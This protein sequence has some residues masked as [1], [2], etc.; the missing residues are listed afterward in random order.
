[1]V[2][3][4][5]EKGLCSVICLGYNHANFLKNNIESIWRQEY[6]KKEIIV[7][8]DGSKDNSLDLLQKLTA[9]APIPM[10]VISQEN[11][12]NIGRNFNNGLKA[13]RGEFVLFISLDDVLVDNIISM[14]ADL[15]NANPTLAFVANSRVMLI[16]DYG[17]EKT[18][19]D[20]LRID[21]MVDPSASDLL[22]L[23][24]EEFGAFY[25]QNC[26]LRRDVI[27]IV[28]GFNEDMIGDDIVLRIKIFRFLKKQQ[29][30]TFKIL[31]SVGACYRLH[32]NN[33]H[34]NSIRQMKI[35]TECLERFF[36]ERKNPTILLNW[37]KGVIRDSTFEE[38]IE[39]FTFNKRASNLLLEPEIQ[40][41]IF[42]SVIGNRGLY[43]P[44]FKKEKRGEDRTITMFGL[45]KYHYKK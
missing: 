17:S 28:G 15:M 11:T 25:L 41:E 23:E 44:L 8:D 29:K 16:D 32:D 5:Y 31:K 26:M 38:Y 42:K 20:S 12:G 18:S 7:V 36:P 39:M 10:T 30:Y 3:I 33:I 14:R 4:V 1:M 43:I 9:I 27:D 34:K 13:A 6:Q 45:I 19:A 22:E 40:K 21:S 37:A 35:V 2:I 24:Y